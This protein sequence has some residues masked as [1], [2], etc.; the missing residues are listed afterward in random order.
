MSA[1][2]KNNRV[3][4]AAAIAMNV[5]NV[6]DYLFFLSFFFFLEKKEN[7]TLINALHTPL[8]GWTKSV[9]H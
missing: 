4:P 6:V 8:V 7:L 5:L 1:R 9:I 3:Y 2:K